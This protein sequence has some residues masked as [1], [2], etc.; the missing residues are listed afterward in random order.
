MK[1]VKWQRLNNAFLPQDEKNESDEMKNTDFHGETL[2][3]QQ[4][5]TNER[6]LGQKKIDAKWRTVIVCKIA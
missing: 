2:R 3:S 1:K 5:N 6:N 4:K